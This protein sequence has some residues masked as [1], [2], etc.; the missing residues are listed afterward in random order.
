MNQRG[1]EPMRKQQSVRFDDE[2]ND[3]LKQQ[4]LQQRRSIAEIIRMIVEDA[5][6]NGWGK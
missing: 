6:A 2:T 5:R 1:L 4:A 3:W